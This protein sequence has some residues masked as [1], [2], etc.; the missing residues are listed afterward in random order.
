M[1]VAPSSRARLALLD[2]AERDPA[3]AALSLWCRH[4]DGPGP[5]AQTRGDTILYGPGFSALTPPEQVGLAAHHILHVAFRHSARAEAMAGREGTRFDRRLFNIAADAIVN[6]TVL[7]AGYVLPRP[8]IALEDLLGRALQDE[9]NTNLAAWDVERLYHRLVG[10]TGTAG[11]SPAEDAKRQAEASGFEDDL[12]SDRGADPEASAKAGLWQGHLA[13]ALAEGRAAGRGLGRLAGRL[14][15]L[16]RTDTPWERILRDAIGK[17]LSIRPDLSPLRPSRR[18]LA[19]D[20]DARQSGRETPAFEPRT[21][22]TGQRPRLAVLMDASSSVTQRLRSRFAAE[23]AGMA[24][25][26]GAEIHLILFDTDVRLAR[27]LP[28]HRVA[29][30]LKDIALP[31]GGGTDF[32]PA[33]EAAIDRAPSMIVALTDLGAD[34]PDQPNVPVIWALPN[35]GDQT[36]PFG[37]AIALDR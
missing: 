29:A 10:G 4:L 18:W 7:E 1:S 27:R 17:A 35:G 6:E 19:G 30:M 34:P 13:R 15:D 21:S 16:P 23:I 9:R 33:F 37:Q 11:R 22:R 20:A 3:L 31:E 5:P 32:G 24:G 8:R 25:R 26:T 2:L 36:P 28:D 14:G 12:E